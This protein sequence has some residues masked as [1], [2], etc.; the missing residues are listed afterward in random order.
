M[1][2]WQNSEHMYRFS[3][4]GEAI[5][6]YQSNSPNFYDCSGSREASLRSGSRHRQRDKERL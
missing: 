1:G 5:T 3:V 4:F 6:M 2:D